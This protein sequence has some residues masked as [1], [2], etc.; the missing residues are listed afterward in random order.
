MSAGK[1]NT[2][3]VT[4]TNAVVLNSPWQ[5]A[6][7]VSHPGSLVRIVQEALSPSPLADIPARLTL[8]VEYL[9]RTDIFGPN[10][11]KHFFNVEVPSAPVSLELETTLQSPCPFWPGRLV[12][13]T[14]EVIYIPAT[15]NQEALTPSK[16]NQLT[17]APTKEFPAVV[18]ACADA[19]ASAALLD[20]SSD[21]SYWVLLTTQHIDLLPKR[22]KGYLQM[23]TLLPTA[24]KGLWQAPLIR[25]ALICITT[26]FVKAKTWLYANQSIHTRHT[27]TQ[28][29]SFVVQGNTDS[30]K[31][32]RLHILPIFYA[33]S[34]TGLALARTFSKSET[35]AAAKK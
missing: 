25:D 14:H 13:D 23:T 4:A 5:R 16:M 12:R 27:E 33:K 22:E 11:W 28:G 1:V 24:V 30:D 29:G 10:E 3:D 6:E 9:Q 31:V 15:V 7:W 35:A 32:G 20:D 34:E 19:T 21:D 26:T 17:L 2:S 8:I 18:S